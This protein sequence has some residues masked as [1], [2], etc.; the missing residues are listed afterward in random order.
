[1]STVPRPLQ[2]HGA[3]HAAPELFTERLRL[4]QWRR[5]D[6]VVM[7]R[8]NA[9]PEV[10]RYLSRPRAR[11]PT[12]AFYETVAAHW[13]AHGFGFWAV[14]ART[15]ERA[16]DLLGFIGLGYPTFI[17]LLATRVEIGWRLARHAWGRGLA[18]EGA[19]VVRDH[20]WSDLGLPELIS[21]IDPE[22]ARSQRVAAKLGMTLT[23][24]VVHPLT[25]TGLDVWR[26]IRPSAEQLDAAPAVAAADAA[27]APPQQAR[28]GPR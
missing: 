12:T 6:E 16:G 13:E 5:A 20:A 19:T 1:M 4:R 8:I 22:N 10:T 17:P 25:W 27:A 3:R 9:D 11:V 18:T 21:I 7:A 14:E 15:G 2:Q 28:T 24:R 23:A 26:L